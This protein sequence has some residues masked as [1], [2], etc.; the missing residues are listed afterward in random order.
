V[1]HHLLPILAPSGPSYAS[2][3]AACASDYPPPPS[4]RLLFMP[5]HP[6][7]GASPLLRVW[8]TQS[9]SNPLLLQPTAF[10]PKT[11]PFPAGAPTPYTSRLPISS[12]EYDSRHP[13][14]KTAF[15]GAVIHSKC[16]CAT[17]FTLLMPTSKPLT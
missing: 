15:V 7:H 9:G 13:S 5:T 11:P 1:W 6:T 16:I 14:S 17:P 2:S 4:I 8:N 10:L 12:I 3:N